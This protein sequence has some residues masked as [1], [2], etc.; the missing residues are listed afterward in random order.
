MSTR[1][2]IVQNTCLL[3]S[4]HQ[5]INMIKTTMALQQE[6][7]ADEQFSRPGR[8]AQDNALSKRLVFDYYRLTKRPFGMCACNLKSCYDRVV[9]TAASLALQRVGVP[10]TEIQCMFR[11]IQKLIHWVRT[12]FG[13]SA[14]S[15]GGYNK[16]YQKPPQGMGQGNGVGPTVW[17]ILS[18]TI[19]EELHA[20]GY[21]T[22]FGMAI[23]MGLYQL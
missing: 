7:I 19:F 4:I 5:V 18:S 10:L 20:C 2:K 23:S 13:L 1:F 6:K 12:A 8:S 21:S 11:T 22:S 16:K 15:F 9:H 14:K 17:S 3:W